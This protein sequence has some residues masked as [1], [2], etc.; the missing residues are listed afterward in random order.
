MKSHVWICTHI[1]YTH[2][3]IFSLS[4][5]PFLCTFVKKHYIISFSF[6]LDS[7]ACSPKDPGPFLGTTPVLT[8]DVQEDGKLIF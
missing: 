4:F 1:H 7:T 2:M 6:N 5:S 8:I 3:Y